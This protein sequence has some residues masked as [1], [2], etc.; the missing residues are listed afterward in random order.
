MQTRPEGTHCTPFEDSGRATPTSRD[1][2]AENSLRPAGNSECGP[3]L[4]PGFITVNG[5][6]T[7]DQFGRPPLL[8]SVPKSFAAKGLKGTKFVI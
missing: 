8:G 6:W 7:Q 5:L 2:Q 3:Y 1:Q 4:K